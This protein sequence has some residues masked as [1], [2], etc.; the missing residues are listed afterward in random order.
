MKIFLD[1]EFTNL[2]EPDLISVGL[3]SDH[4]AELYI[5]LN[6]FDHTK[7]SDFVEANVSPLLHLESPEV[8]SRTQAIVRMKGWLVDQRTSAK[9]VI[10]LVADHPIDFELIPSSVISKVRN[11]EFFDVYTELLRPSLLHF[12]ADQDDWHRQMGI[13]HH[14]LVDAR[15]LK[16]AWNNVGR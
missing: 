13:R 11:I 10:Q 7:C 15:G 9:E 14:A 2:D 3:V 12:T 16:Y 5:V 6:D 1:T 8:L 4:G